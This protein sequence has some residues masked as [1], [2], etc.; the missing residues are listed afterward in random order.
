MIISW[1]QSWA[2]KKADLDPFIETIQQYKESLAQLEEAQL[3]ADS[4]DQEMHE[5]GRCRNRYPGGK[6]PEP[7]NPAQTQC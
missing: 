5:A 6:D 3:L 2:R 1:R 4:G 7:G